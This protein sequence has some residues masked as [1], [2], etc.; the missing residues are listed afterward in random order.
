MDSEK[1]RSIGSIATRIGCTLIGL[2]LLY[3]LSYGP[4]IYVDQGGHPDWYD[5]L[6]RKIY[7]P[8]NLVAHGTPLQRPLDAYINF[9]LSL[10]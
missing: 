4:A 7:A 3:V 1:P 6:F 8:L 5:S 10:P 9:W 2:V